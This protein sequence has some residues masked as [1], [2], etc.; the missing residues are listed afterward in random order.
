MANSSPTEVASPVV[1]PTAPAAAPMAIANGGV[2]ATGNA[3]VPNECPR[4]ALSSM[5][6]NMAPLGPKDEKRKPDPKEESESSDSD[7][8][9]AGDKDKKKKKKK[10]GKKTP[11]EVSP[12]A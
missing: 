6:T 10:K 2:A 4:M 5:L 9:G 11:K 7:E 8:A 3:P 12:E 1:E